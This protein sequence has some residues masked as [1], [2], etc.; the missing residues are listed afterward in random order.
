MQL[1]P[2]YLVKNR[3]TVIANEAGFVTEY[4]PVY[5]RQLQVYKG[6]D[7]VLDFRILN[8]DQKP[9]NIAN[10][11]PKFQAFDENKSLIIA[12]DGVAI[13]GD[14]SAAI[15]GLFKVTITANDLLNVNGQFISYSIHLEDAD[16]NNVITYSDSHFG[17]NGTIEV[18]TTAYPGPRTSYSISTFNPDLG[19][20]GVED[21]VWNSEALNAEPG[22]N[23]NEALHTAVIYANAYVGN[24]IVQATLDNQISSN[25]TNSW[26]DIATVSF[27]GTET[28]PKSVNFNGVYSHLRFRTTADPTDKITKILVRN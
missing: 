13:A 21:T 26:A 24:V 6:I 28:E 19:L 11:T 18:S 3:T 17:N 15:R 8:A 10:Y 2:R 12:H 25:N 23:G 5:S 14:D 7:N 9:I 27:D 20:P 16:G 1:I 22:I 4:R